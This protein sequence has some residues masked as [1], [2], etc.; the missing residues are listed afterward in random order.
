MFTTGSKFFFG[1]AAFGLA[2][3]AVYGLA[4]SGSQI[5]MDALLGVVTLGYKGQVGEHLGYSTLIGLAVASAFLG[6][7][8]AAFRDADAE[9]QAEFVGAEIVPAAVAPTSGSYWPI[10]AGFA[11]T[12][13]ALGLAVSSVLF[14]LGLVALAVVLVEWMVKAWSERATAD[15]EVNRA[16]RNR[17]MT[18]V[19]IPGIAIIGIALVVLAVS[20]VLLALPKSGSTVLA[21]VLPALILGVAAIIAARPKVGPTVVAVLCLL[22]GLGVLAGGVIGAVV[23][24]REFH[25][26]EDE[27]VEE[28]GG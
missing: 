1:L 25:G 27:S 24:E 16:I 5:G 14:V 23:G 17:I 15:P 9:A 3:A 10:V 6:C 18:P 21:I 19:E 11:V 26:H 13:T 28:P 22:G 20:R 4:T 8:I 12:T 7:V 2:A